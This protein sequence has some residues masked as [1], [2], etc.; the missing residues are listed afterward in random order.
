M[1]DWWHSGFQR[2]CDCDVFYLTAGIQ[3]VCA[4]CWERE[5]ELG[6]C[7]VFS[8]EV[9]N[10]AQVSHCKEIIPHSSQATQTKTRFIFW[11]GAFLL[12][13]IFRF[14]IWGYLQ[15]IIFKTFHELFP[16]APPSPSHINSKG[17][18][19]SACVHTHTCMYTNPCTHTQTTNKT[20]TVS[21]RQMYDRG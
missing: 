3:T 1:E 10:S 16:T 20:T 7:V 21:Q 6:D 9:C 15:K 13:Y 17:T 19:K 18:V 5:E 2:N 11:F 8:F 12:P 4:K 14:T